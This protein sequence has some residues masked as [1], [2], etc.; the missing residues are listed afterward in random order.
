MTWYLGGSMFHKKLNILG[1][2][3]LIMLLSGCS[4]L[5]QLLVDTVTPELT[6]VGNPYI[7]NAELPIIGSGNVVVRVP[8]EAYNPNLVGIQ[9]TKVDMG[10]FLNNGFVA[11]GVFEDT[12][13]VA[14]SGRTEFNV[15]VNIPIL[16]VI[17]AF[18]AISDLFFGNPT[19]VTV[20]AIVTIDVLD[21]IKVS[22]KTIIFDASVSQ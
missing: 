7:V 17:G 12:R 18:P 6:V 21:I 14:S 1:L 19:R 20:D 13:S 8:V 15:D 10:L 9:L 4:T 2:V 3:T 11:N 22:G 16:N 5:Q